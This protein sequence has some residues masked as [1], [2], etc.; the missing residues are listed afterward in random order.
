MGFN[1]A[2]LCVYKNKVLIQMFGGMYIKLDKDGP[3]SKA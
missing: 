2:M 1:F 3:T